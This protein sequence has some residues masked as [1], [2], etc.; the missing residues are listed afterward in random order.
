MFGL[1]EKASARWGWLLNVSRNARFRPG[2]SNL[3]RLISS[4]LLCSLSLI[5]LPQPPTA[6]AAPMSEEVTCVLACNARTRRCSYYPVSKVPG[7]YLVQRAVPPRYKLV[8]SG[9][10]CDNKLCLTKSKSICSAGPIGQ[11]TTAIDR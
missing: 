5:V 3:A 2:A 1:I 11:T 4:L 8:K 10:T 6:S 9:S 7:E